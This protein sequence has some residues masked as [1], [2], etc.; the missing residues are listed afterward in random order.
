MRNA[1]RYSTTYQRKR[2]STGI[3]TNMRSVFVVRYA[4][5]SNSFFRSRAG[6]YSYKSR[7]WSLPAPQTSQSSLPCLSFREHTAKQFTPGHSTST[8]ISLSDH[9]I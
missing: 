4:D 2:R 8:L 6:F 9:L 1:T 7:I 5:V 3:L